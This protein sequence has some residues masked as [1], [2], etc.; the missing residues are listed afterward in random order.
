MHVLTDSAII[1]VY[2][3]L[4][5]DVIEMDGKELSAQITSSFAAP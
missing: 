5:L 3:I 4:V 2:S 1:L